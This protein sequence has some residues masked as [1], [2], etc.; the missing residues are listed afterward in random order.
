MNISPISFSG[1]WINRGVNN[2]ISN[3]EY[4]PFSDE[5]SAQIKEQVN[6][7]KKCGDIYKQ[8]KISSRNLKQ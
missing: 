3:Y 5:T 7:K 6:K 4:R 1:L 8:Q 2:K